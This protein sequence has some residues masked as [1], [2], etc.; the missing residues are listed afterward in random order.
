MLKKLL[1]NEFKATSRIYI[2]IYLVFTALL[3]VE[4]LSIFASSS[5]VRGEGFLFQISE[6][7][8]GIVTILTVLGIIA[9]CVTPAIYS[10]YRF[11]KNMLSDEGYLSF[12]LPVTV[13]Q[14]LWSKVI[15]SCIWSIVTVLFGC[16]VGGLFLL[17]LDRL[18]VFYVMQF[19]GDTICFLHQEAG[20]WFYVAALLFILTVLVQ[21]VVSFLTYYSAM[22]IGQCANKH[23][24]LVSV[25]VY[26][27]FSIATS[28]ILQFLNMAILFASQGSIPERIYQFMNSALASHA[29][30]II[31][32]Q[33]LCL[34]F[35][36]GSLVNC[37]FGLAHFLIS[38]HFLT[39]KLNLA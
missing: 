31:M 32:C 19:L 34:L 22:S 25:A 13:S 26:V 24:F 7:L 33:A 27:G 29:P 17:T 14:H 1:K 28:T 9:L 2:A 38:K 16:L 10:I 12:T 11:Y 4:R 5:T 37:L 21:L 20:I 18:A 6:F 39:K 30:S 3:T 15:V 35:L 8:A 23:K 36:A